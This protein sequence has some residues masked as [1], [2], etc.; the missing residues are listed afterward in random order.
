MTDATTP[1]SAP[2]SSTTPGEAA[3]PGHHSYAPYW[4]AWV[5]LLLLTVTMIFIQNPV[6]LAGGICIKA[7]IIC[8]WFMHLS[9][10]K[11]DLTATFVIGGLFFAIFMFLL[12]AVDASSLVKLG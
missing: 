1:A 12:F 3:D 5:I 2:A 8:W 9:Q 6:V 7:T 10:E 4:I 11:W